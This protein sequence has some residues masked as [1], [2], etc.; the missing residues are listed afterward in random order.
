MSKGQEAL[1]NIGVCLA[2]VAF[3]PLYA[4][5]AVRFQRYAPGLARR[6]VHMRVFTQAVSDALIARDGSLANRGE[7][8]LDS[9]SESAAEWPLFEVV[10][11][12]PVQRVE[13]PKGWRHQPAYFQ[14]LASYCEERRREIDVV[15][16]LSLSFWAAPWMR[17]FRRLG[18]GTVFTHT[19]LGELSTNPWKRA[20]R[21]IYWRFPFNLVDCVVVSSSAMRRRL[22]ALGV[23][24]LIEV[25]PNGVDLRRF[26]PLANAEA[27][28]RLRAKLGLKP[29]WEIILAVGPIIPRKGTDV[30]VEAFVSLCHDY[31]NAHLVLVGPRHDLNRET[32]AGFRQR[33]QD[34]IAAANARHRVIFTG[35]VS[36]VEDYLQAA[37]LLVFPSRR[38]GMPNVV[39]EAMACGLATILTSFLGLPDE[40]GHSGEHYVLAERTPQALAATIAA[41][42]D[43]PERRQQLGRQARE[44][45]EKQMDVEKSLD[46]YASLYR[47]LADRSRE[48]RGQA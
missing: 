30:L 42:L 40:F 2:S 48:G 18:I 3:Y 5:P 7:S 4:G 39:P 11:G 22:E 37:D 10:D 13:L 17:Q 27:K 31:P 43:D 33:L 6:G 1:T 29:G 47:Q 36:N 26:R 8:D 9:L 24:A 38:E 14:R 20:L 16:F 28:A 21:R 44:W 46:R 34:T 35:A 23:S 15:Q 19:L 41:L 12:L 32:L 45:V 25:I